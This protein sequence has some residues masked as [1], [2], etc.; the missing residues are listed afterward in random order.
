MALG[1]GISHKMAR[2]WPGAA[3]AFAIHEYVSLLGLAFAIFHAIVILGDHYINFTFVQLLVPFA[4]VG[5]RPLWVGVGQIGFYVWV[6]VAATFYIRKLIGQKTWRVVHYLS[7]AM[8]L[9]G[10][11]HGLFSGTD[12]SAPWAQSYYW[13]SGSSLLFLTMARIIGATVDKL[14]PARPAPRQAPVPQS[15]APSVPR[16]A[17][18]PIPNA[19]PSPSMKTSNPVPTAPRAKQ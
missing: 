5:Y 12:A 7:F 19:T 18:F 17:P 15:P 8:Y 1:I 13:I 2:T 9:M 11:F 14:A 3:A 4:T 6:I 16:Q 10:L